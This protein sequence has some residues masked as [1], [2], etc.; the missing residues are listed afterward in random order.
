MKHLQISLDLKISED[1]KYN[2][3]PVNDEDIIENIKFQ[4]ESLG[5]KILREETKDVSE[6]YIKELVLAYIN[7]NGS[8]KDYLDS[9]IELYNEDEQFKEAVDNEYDL[10][11]YDE[12]K[13][14]QGL[15]GCEIS[16]DNFLKISR[17]LH[18]EDITVLELP[19]NKSEIDGDD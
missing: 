10:F 12:W 5:A 8:T 4:I 19:Y 2:G 11:D 15:I 9:F 7:K 18:E 14:F 13:H 6:Y 16:F 3:L 1:L 17:I